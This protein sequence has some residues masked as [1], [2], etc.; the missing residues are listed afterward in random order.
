MTCKPFGNY[1]GNRNSGNFTSYAKDCK[2]QRSYKNLSLCRRRYQ[3]EQ[4]KVKRNRSF[5]RNITDSIKFYQGANEH[6]SCS[7]YAREAYAHTVKDKSS[8]E[9]HQQENIDKTVGTG[10]ESVFR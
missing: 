8:K 1:L 3:P 10:K 2:T 4:S 6:K 7:H 5:R 9:Q